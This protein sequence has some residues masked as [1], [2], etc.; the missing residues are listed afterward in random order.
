MMSCNKGFWW[1]VC[2]SPLLARQEQLEETVNKRLQQIEHNLISH[3]NAFKPAFDAQGR[4]IIL[5]LIYVIWA[6]LLI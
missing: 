2:C 5:F 4:P 6:L 3:M 1:F